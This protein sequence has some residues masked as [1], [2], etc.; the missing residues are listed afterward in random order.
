MW[1]LPSLGDELPASQDRL[2]SIKSDSYVPVSLMSEVCNFINN[3]FQ[4]LHSE[5]LILDD[6]IKAFHDSGG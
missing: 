6:L 5:T 3:D 4:W 1:E 2:C